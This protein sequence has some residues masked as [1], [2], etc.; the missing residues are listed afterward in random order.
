V[1][2]PDAVL[3]AIRANRVTALADLTAARLAGDQPR[4]ALLEALLGASGVVLYEPG[5]AHYSVAYGDV[6]P[7]R[8]VALFIPGMGDDANL[9]ADWI[10]WAERL[11]RSAGGAAVVLWKG[12]DNPPGFP[13]LDALSGALADRAVQGA[14]RLLEFT[15]ILAVREDQTFTIV[16]HSYGS[17]VAGEALAR[18]GGALRVTDLVVLGSPGMGVERLSQLHL[19]PR[20]C[21]A[22]QAPEDVVA[23]LGLF[24]TAPS[25]PLFGAV[26]MATNAEGA[27]VVAAHSS[28]FTSG[29]AALANIAD[30]VTGQ[31][32][33]VRR[34]PASVG[35]LVGAAVTL[36]LKLPLLPL[37]YVEDR[38]RGPGARLVE[39]GDSLA[40]LA[41]AEAG[42]L[43]AVG[44]ERAAAGRR[45]DEAAGDGRG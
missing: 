24:G 3:A 27:P 10:P 4:V 18:G 41:A 7:A 31:Y 37:V 38:Y 5:T 33:R 45:G 32:R 39:L 44:I 26:R 12:Y 22:E 1:A 28:Y 14:A 29:S 20:H 16:A 17:L 6:R 23:E 19:E 40:N 34:E 9:V 8:H 15:D 11:H 35:E 2:P 13:H 42:R 43:V 21:F 25:S 36:A 30:V